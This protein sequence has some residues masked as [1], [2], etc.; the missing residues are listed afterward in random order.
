MDD[1][2]KNWIKK[3]K[4]EIGNLNSSADK[5]KSKAISGYSPK[6]S[7]K[8]E[9]I[10]SVDQT[11]AIKIEETQPVQNT[12]AE[13]TKSDTPTKISE[14]APLEDE[15]KEKAKQNKFLPPQSSSDPMK[16]Q[17]P[18]KHSLLSKKSKILLVLTII[19]IPIF[20]FIYFYIL[21]RI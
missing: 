5:L 12:V 10:P 9:S 16:T 14:S 13:I 2:V 6:E 19:W 17:Y 3:K 21:P 4:S 15:F 18:P 8:P 1:E 20:L 7:S 11:K